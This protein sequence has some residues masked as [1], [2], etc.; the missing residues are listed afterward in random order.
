MTILT[1][2]WRLNNLTTLEATAANK[3]KA[4]FFEFISVLDYYYHKYNDLV[5]LTI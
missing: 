4:V 3:Q 2:R 1:W 5:K